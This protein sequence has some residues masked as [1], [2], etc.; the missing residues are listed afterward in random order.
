MMSR[1]L[2]EKF[3]TQGFLKASY[4]IFT[5]EEFSRLSR[6]VLKAV[7]NKLRQKSGF[8]RQAWL[9]EP[10]LIEFA[11]NDKLV[12]F[13]NSFLGS[14]IGVFASS[15]YKKE[16]NSIFEA[17]WHSDVSNFD[18]VTQGLRAVSVT[19]AISDCTEA[20]GC[21]EYS[22]GSHLKRVREHSYGFT[23]E[24]SLFGEEQHYELIDAEVKSLAPAAL[25][26]LKSSEVSVADLATVH[27]SG[28]NLSANDRVILVFRYFS[29]SSDSPL[30]EPAKIFWR[31]NRHTFLVSGEDTQGICRHSLVVKPK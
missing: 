8:L 29:T 12:E 7:D 18:Q 27:R 19:I 11:C 15:I 23:P 1:E 21:L 3:E 4:P 28:P 26:E 9:V 16:A 10:D 2:I 17:P 24:N 20:S 30:T 25:M 13:L 22:P 31:S 5:A 14:N 6:C